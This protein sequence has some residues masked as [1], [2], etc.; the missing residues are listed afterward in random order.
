VEPAEGR[1]VGTTEGRGVGAVGCALGAGVGTPGGSVG[2]AVGRAVGLVEGNA[3]EGFAVER[4]EGKGVGRVVG[5]D[6]GLIVVGRAV[7]D[8]VGTAVG[9]AVCVG[10]AVGPYVSR[11]TPVP[12]TT[13]KPE[14]VDEPVQPSWIRYVCVAV[15]AGTVYCT[16][17]QESL[18]D[19]HAAGGRLLVPV[20]SYTTSIP[21]GVYTRSVV[22][23]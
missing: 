22:F 15:P 19:M 1:T 17:A 4:A 3:V 12:A 2:F 5:G 14:H 6:E 8:V 13:A 11:W 23:P 21:V 18:P 20:S 7:V 16:C 10:A 9:T